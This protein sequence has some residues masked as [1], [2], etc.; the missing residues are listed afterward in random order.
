MSL[1][2]DSARRVLAMNRACASP[3]TVPVASAVPPMPP[4]CIGSR[5]PAAGGTKAGFSAGTS[6]KIAAMRSPSASRCAW[7]PAPLATKGLPPSISACRASAAAAP[8]SASVIRSG[9]IIAVARSASSLSSP[10]GSSVVRAVQRSRSPCGRRS[11]LAATVFSKPAAAPRVTPCSAAP[12]RKP[13]PM[14]MA[15]SAA[16]VSMPMLRRASTVSGSV[17][18]VIPA[19]TTPSISMPRR[20]PVPAEKP[21]VARPRPRFTGSAKPAAAPPSSCGTM[22]P[23]AAVSASTA[24]APNRVRMPSS[25][26]SRVCGTSGKAIGSRARARSISCHTRSRSIFSVVARPAPPTRK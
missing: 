23:R 21:P 15:T 6:R 9:P 22:P 5:S 26:A 25:K 16:V 14:S 8:A 4:G 2:L 19:F 11:Q 7:L 3:A 10:A 18:A 12:N 20:M 1:P 17:A 24:A 13:P